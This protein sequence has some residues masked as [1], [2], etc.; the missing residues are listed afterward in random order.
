MVTNKPRVV[1]RTSWLNRLLRLGFLDLNRRK[2][3]I[4]AGLVFFYTF[5][6][7]GSG[8]YSQIRLWKQ[9][10][11]IQKNI[12]LEKK[13]RKWLNDQADALSK[14]MSRIQM[15]AR[16]ESGLGQKDEIMIQIQQ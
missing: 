5:V 12:E 1:R 11:D 15:E 8:F 4:L 13:K 9:G 7:G 3:Y 16:K 10:H 2:V 14:D 6:A